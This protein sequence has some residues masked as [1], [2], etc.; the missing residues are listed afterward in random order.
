MFS[1]HENT[2]TL[3]CRVAFAALCLFPTLLTLAWSAAIRL[4][5]YQRGHEA[6]ISQTLGLKAQ[7]SRV[8]TPRPGTTLYEWLELFDPETKQLLARL[9]FVEVTTPSETVRIKLPFPGIVN[10]TRLDAIWKLGHDL[11]R[12]QADGRPVRFEAQNLTL[13]LG[14]AGDQTFTDVDARLDPSVDQARFSLKFRRAVASAKPATPAE[15]TVIRRRQGTARGSVVQFST[16]STP[17]ACSL[18]TSV[19][20]A[21]ARFG[22]SCEFQGRIFVPD[23]VGP[24]HAQLDGRLT[25]IDLDQLV[26]QQFPHVLTGMADAQFELIAG[27]DGRIE[28]ALGTITAHDGIVSRSLLQSAATHLHVRAHLESAEGDEKLLPYQDLSANVAISAQGL[29]LQGAVA[30]VPGALIVDSTQRVM[31]QEPTIGRQNVANLARA[32]VP[33]SEVQ[34]PATLETA[35]LLSLLP[36]PS[37]HGGSEEQP[38]E[39][40]RVRIKGARGDD[41]MQR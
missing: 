13:H 17:L 16:G 27:A 37:L 21:V 11:A 14:E 8:S 38:L 25:R 12:A 29:V 22:K 19:W 10:G 1:L 20:P 2:R 30:E 33:Q 9:P 39:A 40:R 18:V 6:A 3:C 35:G 34:V 32:L 31:L 24:W 4:P 15:L 28:K 41:R 26:S 7:L 23:Q 36:I 5:F